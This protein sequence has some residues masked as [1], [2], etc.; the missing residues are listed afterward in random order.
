ML[1]TASSVDPV[2]KVVGRGISIFGLVFGIE[3][4]AEVVY[5]NLLTSDSYLLLVITIYPQL[6]PYQIFEESYQIA[7][8]L[9]KTRS[10]A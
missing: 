10:F 6:K 4:T 2:G 5:L 3:V 9:Y 1:F 7:I 8:S